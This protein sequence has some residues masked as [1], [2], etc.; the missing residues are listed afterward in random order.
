MAVELEQTLERVEAEDSR[1]LGVEEPYTWAEC[2]FLFVVQQ[3]ALV[4]VEVQMLQLN[5]LWSGWRELPLYR[6]Q[7]FLHSARQAEL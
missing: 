4:E 6:W 2:W 1:Q 7:T 5:L 3:A